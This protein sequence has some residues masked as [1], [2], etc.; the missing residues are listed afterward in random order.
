MS[1]MGSH[2][3]IHLHRHI[4]GRNTKGRMP[5][6]DGALGAECRIEEKTGKE[7]RVRLAAK[8]QNL[9]A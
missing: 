9:M 4:T 3:C 2:G 8:D 5:A 1:Q 7:I 6:S